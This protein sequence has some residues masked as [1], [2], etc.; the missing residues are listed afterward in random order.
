MGG[1]A[2]AARRRIDHCCQRMRRSGLQ[3]AAWRVSSD[4]SGI[5]GVGKTYRSSAKLVQPRN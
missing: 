2:K 1:M 5:L 4:E 3:V